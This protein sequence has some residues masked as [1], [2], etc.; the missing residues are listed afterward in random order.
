MHAAPATDAGAATAADH[1]A[2]AV[3]MVLYFRWSISINPFCFVVEIL[4]K[5][6]R[7]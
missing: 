5:Q 4:Y 3:L 7:K 6:A 1:A 2:A